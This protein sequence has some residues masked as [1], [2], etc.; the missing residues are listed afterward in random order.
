MTFRSDSKSLGTATITGDPGRS[1]AQRVR[2]GAQFLQMFTGESWGA[3]GG[4]G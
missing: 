3:D 1:R 2:D 4:Y